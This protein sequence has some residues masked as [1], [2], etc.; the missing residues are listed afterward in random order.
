MLS[1]DLGLIAA[2]ATSPKIAR[3][4]SVHGYPT[5][6]FAVG[7]GVLAAIESFLD[8]ELGSFLL[9]ISFEY[10]ETVLEISTILVEWRHS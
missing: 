4:A 5:K 8:S 6:P 2:I 9:S 10:L 3:T 7:S 1:L